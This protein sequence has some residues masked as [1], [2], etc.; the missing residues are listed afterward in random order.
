[1][2]S[3]ALLLKEKAHLIL[4]QL[5]YLLSI[6][7]LG[8]IMRH[9]GEPLSLGSHKNLGKSLVHL[10]PCRCW[11][12]A[13][14]HQSLLASDLTFPHLDREDWIFLHFSA[15]FTFIVSLLSY[16]QRSS[17]SGFL[18]SGLVTN[19]SEIQCC[20]ISSKVGNILEIWALLFTCWGTV[21]Q[22]LMF[23]IKAT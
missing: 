6:K 22:L 10:S 4:L 14:P 23:C 8:A 17:V 1:M 18:K 9:G 13:V 21:V 11:P 12:R 7:P 16:Q 2:F 5:M 19:I 3:H 15:N 20:E